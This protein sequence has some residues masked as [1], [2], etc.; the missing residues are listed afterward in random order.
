MSAANPAQGLE[1]RPSVAPHERED[2]G[3]RLDLSANRLLDRLMPA[4]VTISVVSA[5]LLGEHPWLTLAAGILFGLGNVALNAVRE[6]NAGRWGGRIPRWQAELRFFLT[7]VLCPVIYVSAGIHANAWYVAVAPTV[8][9]TVMFRDRYQLRPVLL[10]LAIAGAAHLAG[11]DWT[12]VVGEFVG[13][14]TVGL[15][16][17]PLID[18]LRRR[19]VEAYLAADA[20]NEAAEAKASFLATMSH[21]VRT[22]L[23]GMLGMVELLRESS[24]EPEQREWVGHLRASGSL[25]RG[26]VSDILDFSKIEAGKL[27]LSPQAFSPASLAKRAVTAVQPL[28][29]DKRIALT[30]TM[31]PELPAYLHGDAQRLE[32]VLLNLLTNA[33]KFTEEGTVGVQFCYADGQLQFSVSDT[34]IGI[35]PSQLE[36]L[37]RPFEQADGST[38]RR[39]GGTGLGLAICG[40]LCALMGGQIVA[41]SQV[42]RGSRFAVRVPAQ[43]CEAPPAPSRPDPERPVGGGQTVLVAEDNRVNQIVIRNLL[44]KRGFEVVTANNGLDAVQA[45]TVR[46]YDLV[47]MDCHMPELD[48]YQAT[49]QIRQQ[50]IRGPHRV[51]IVAL[52]ADAGA[53]ARRRCMA[54]GMDDY[55]TKPVDPA[56]LDRILRRFVPDVARPVA[57]PVAP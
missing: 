22:P 26:V 15:V 39:F 21:E 4:P 13:L 16:A 40:R 9:L 43:P 53:E 42:G 50:E 34:G 27:A 11:A 3:A 6:R 33:V 56:D 25:L 31:A 29:A 45:L 51:P 36:R 49:A 41:H 24:L 38:S 7:L 46:D 8:A 20:A 35:A 14:V 1:A 2:H 10:A 54:A 18:Q 37:F 23:N 28:A 55:M 30:C 47:F 48:G 52:T 32:Q 12:W 17:G 19:S 57:R 5:A 44:K